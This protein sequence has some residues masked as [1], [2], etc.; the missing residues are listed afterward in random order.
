MVTWWRRFALAALLGFAAQANDL[1]MAQTPAPAM[2]GRVPQDEIVYFLLPDRFANGDPANDR[3]GLEGDRL[4]TGFDPTDPGFYQG[5]DLKGLTARLDYI[6]SLGATAIWL[7]PIYK[8][9]PVQGAGPDVSAG[10]HGYW[11]TDFLDVD[12]HF[13]T[14]ADLHAFMKAAHARGLKVYLD[15][16]VNHTAD[17]IQYRECPND[18]VLNPTRKGCPYR[19]IA[20]YPW[21]RKGGLRGPEINRGFRGDGPSELTEQ[22]FARLTRFDWAYTPF[23]APGDETAKNPPWLN[24]L[25]HYHH[26]GDTT[27][28]GESSLY[29]DFHGLDD[30]ATEDP[31]VVQGMIDIFKYWISEFRVDGFRIDTTKHARAEFWNAFMPAMAA[32]AK[33]EGIENFYMFGEV[34]DFNA[35]SL[36]RYT[37]EF[38]MPAVIDF[39]FQGTLRGVVIDGK[40]ARDFEHMFA[41]DAAYADGRNTAAILPTFVSNHDMGR[42]GGFLT[43]A[44]PNMADEERVKRV[45]LGHA[46]MFFMRGVPVMYSGDEQGFNSDSNDRH[47]RETLFA[48]RVASW[49]DNDLIGTTRTNAEDNFRTD[50]PIFQGIAGLSAI[51][52]AHSALRRGQQVIRFSDEKEGVIAI[53]RIEPGAKEEY[54]VVFNAETTP[55]RLNVIVEPDSLTWRSVKGNCARAANAAGSY[56]V[57]VPP[58]DVLICRGARN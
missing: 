20:D 8:N 31:A 43:K 30:I 39:A 25:R 48:S 7:G 44:H 6:Q 41:I 2:A 40:P 18:L 26:R 42:F 33:A 22:N 47:A 10:Y 4:V 54:L 23:L 37:R 34:Y 53:S 5:G 36:A 38:S 9:K 55:A 46:M 27:F 19:A 17:I 3:G 11:I 24:N 12:P 35:G 56:S 57:M 28:S 21:T 32:H 50:H 13:G 58:L 29:G 14:K 45:L 51:R 52:Q 49:N 15:I 16:I 1:V